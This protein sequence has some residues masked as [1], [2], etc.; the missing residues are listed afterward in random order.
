MNTGKSECGLELVRTAVCTLKTQVLLHSSCTNCAPFRAVVMALCD[1]TMRRASR[2]PLASMLHHATSAINVQPNGN[3]PLLQG[4]RAHR[5]IDRVED[6]THRAG[7]RAR[8]RCRRGNGAPELV[9]DARD[10]SPDRGDR[11][12]DPGRDRRHRIAAAR[13]RRRTEDHRPATRPETRRRGAESVPVVVAAPMRVT[14]PPGSFPELRAPAAG[15]PRASAPE[16]MAPVR[17][18]G[19]VGPVE[20]APG[21][22]M[23]PCAAR[24]PV[25]LSLGR[26][27]RRPVLTG[28]GGD[29]GHD[30]C[31]DGTERGDRPVPAALAFPRRSA[32]PRRRLAP[33]APPPEKPPRKALRHQSGVELPAPAPTLGAARVAAPESSSRWRSR[34][35]LERVAEH[36]PEQ[37]LVPASRREVVP[38]LAPDAAGSPTELLRAKD[39]L[40]TFHI[41]RVVVLH[42]APL[43]TSPPA[44]PAADCRGL[45]SHLDVRRYPATTLSLARPAR[46]T[47]DRQAHQQRAR[48][49]QRP[50]A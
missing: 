2:P 39:L 29:A 24:R 19:A 42:H 34:R 30:Q 49:D 28:T 45:A 15:G 38:G 44:S 41:T 18:P 8:G 10:R 26:S 1:V 50:R 37:R 5:L 17:E 22:A 13:T 6:T 11:V 47:A 35:A 20:A 4:R 43:P 32:D 14:C 25:L 12:P 3:A 27:V 31:D 9:R 48:S 36:P 7:R 46:R 40:E 21:S 16:P 23:R 33:A